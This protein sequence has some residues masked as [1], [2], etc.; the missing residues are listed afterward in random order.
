[1]E[2]KH[3]KIKKILVPTDFSKTANNAL[4]QA[5]N[6]AKVAGAE[7][8]LLHIIVPAVNIDA[9]MTIPMGDLYYT[10]FQK[11]ISARFKQLA[12]SIKNETGI[13][14][15]Y[16]VGYGIV[17]SE[18]CSI[19]EEEKFDLI[20]MGTHGTSGVTEFFAGSNA[21]KV[22]GNAECPVITVQKKPVKKGFK[23]IVLPIR[24][25]RAS[26][27]KVDYA[28]ELAKLFGSTVFIAG[29]TDRKDEASKDKIVLYVDQVQRYLDKLEIKNKPGLIYAPNFTKEMLKYAEKNKADL[30]AVMNE[31]SFSLDQLIRGP[32]AKQ[33]VNHS[34]IPVMGVP[35]QHDPDMLTYSPYLS[36]SLPE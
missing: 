5:I 10:K 11:N 24:L 27:Q 19:A 33:F 7:I 6:T 18:I 17:H 36:G 4:S 12:A 14:V 22:M 9:T 1:M 21:A 20:I 29:Y 16:E 2:A 32:Y 3:F 34:S 31:N 15:T 8:K 13:K 28:V 35:V 23:N 26:R 30:I 25:E